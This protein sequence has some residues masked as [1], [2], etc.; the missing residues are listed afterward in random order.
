MQL[1]RT[2]ESCLTM[3]QL[4]CCYVMTMTQL[5]ALVGSNCDHET[6]QFVEQLLTRRARPL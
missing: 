6:V 1:F 2:T 3:Q 5:R 4:A